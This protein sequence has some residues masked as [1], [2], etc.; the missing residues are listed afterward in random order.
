[1]LNL[2]S[3]NTNVG[4]ASYVFV[5]GGTIQNVS[6]GTADIFGIG[7]VAGEAGVMTINSGLVNL[8]GVNVNFDHAVPGTLNLNGGTY[9]INNE[10]T[11]TG[12][13]NFNG[14][15]LQLNG[16]VS[17]FVPSTFTLNV[18]DGGANINLN[19]FSTNITQTLNGSGSGGLTVYGTSTGTLTLSGNNNY[20]GPTQINGGVVDVTVGQSY[21]GNTYVSGRGPGHRRLGQQ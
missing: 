12:T 16:N 13:Y 19:G 18:G 6:A 11:G 2:L 10:P 8:S 17:T 14:G 1:M 4:L 5:N 21:T 15:T 9:I 20:T 7:W 3:G